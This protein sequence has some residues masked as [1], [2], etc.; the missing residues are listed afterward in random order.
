[1]II[2]SFIE[3]IE[4]DIYFV[5]CFFD[6]RKPGVYKF[7]NITFDFEP[8]YIGKGKGLRPNRH[9]TL[10][11]KYNNRFYSKM[12]SIIDAGFNP[13]FTILIENLIES[14]AFKM[15]KY[16]I[17]LIGR[18]ESGGTLTNL[19]DG[20]EGQSGFRF[21]DDS[22]KRMSIKRSG[23]KIGP[24]SDK[25]K[26]SISL[27]KIGKPSPIKGKKLEDIVGVVRS[28]II[29]NN[30]S[31]IASDRV[32]D[33]NGMFGRKHSVDS[34]EKMSKNT[35]KLFG[36]DN[37]SFG[38]KRKESEKVYDTWELTDNEGNV[39]IIDN[40]NKFCV[41]NGLNASCMRDLYYGTA[42]SHKKWIKVIKLTNNVKKKKLD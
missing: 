20:G 9:Y 37:P 1:M 12:S 10:Y 19:S 3:H 40:L 6:T 32:G 39:T 11:K 33:K 26:L 30:L 25:T 29:K 22:K 17:S 21:S 35:I 31:K 5:Y 27:S 28:S 34:I 42:K 36:E 7:G 38:I 41:E 15:E 13:D 23:K 2:K 8:I 18:I 14:E 16:F 4:T 24:M